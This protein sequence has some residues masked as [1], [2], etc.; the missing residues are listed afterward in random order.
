MVGDSEC[1]VIESLRDE[2]L[3]FRCNF[4]TFSKVHTSQQ[5][6]LKVITVEAILLDTILDVVI[7]H[8]VR[9]THLH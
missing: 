2:I 5:Y 3:S 1:G 9:P 4:S 7:L 6:E 8:V